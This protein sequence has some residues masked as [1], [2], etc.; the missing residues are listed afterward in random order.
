MKSLGGPA[1]LDRAAVPFLDEASCEGLPLGAQT[2]V[3]MLP[4]ARPGQS[5]PDRVALAV[6]ASP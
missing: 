1:I 3:F 6:L 4:W 2:P 5:L